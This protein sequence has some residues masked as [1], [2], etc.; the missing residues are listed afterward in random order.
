MFSFTIDDSLDARHYIGNNIIDIGLPISY[1]R[2][3]LDVKLFY[4]D[5]GG[6]IYCGSLILT[7]KE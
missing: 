5:G 7:R 3:S 2:D 4:S 1:L 6:E